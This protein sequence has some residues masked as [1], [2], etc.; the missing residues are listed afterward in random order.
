MSG[1]C[2]SCPRS[3][4]DETRVRLIQKYGKPYDRTVLNNTGRS[5]VMERSPVFKLIIA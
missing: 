4:A 5:D 3:A 1:D 2:H